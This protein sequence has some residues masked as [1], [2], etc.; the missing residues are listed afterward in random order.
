MS[1]DHSAHA[2][3]INAPALELI[4]GIL[5]QHTSG[6]LAGTREHIDNRKLSRMADEALLRQAL[7]AL[8]EN[9][10]HWHSMSRKAIAAIKERL[11]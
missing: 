6:I 1:G 11:K 2:R 7:E 10:P 5:E 8:E 9:G 4:A 3:I